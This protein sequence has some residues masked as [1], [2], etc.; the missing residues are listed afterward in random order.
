M[1]LG[2]TKENGKNFKRFE[3]QNK[4]ARPT[5]KASKRLNEKN[6]KGY[7]LPIIRLVTIFYN[8]LNIPDR[9]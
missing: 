5:T 4:G 2:F 6:Q 3:S 7:A 1:E 8:V 9:Y